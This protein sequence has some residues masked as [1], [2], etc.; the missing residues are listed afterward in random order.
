MVFRGADSGAF[1]EHQLSGIAQ[2]TL[3]GPGFFLSTWS[4]RVVHAVVSHHAPSL[5]PTC[6]QTMSFI[7]VHFAERWPCLQFGGTMNRL[8]CILVEG[9]YGLFG[10][11][12]PEGGLPG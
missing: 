2:P 7:P 6:G 4:W 5:Y 11:N 10:V 12:A 1:R 8:L 9:F 3:L